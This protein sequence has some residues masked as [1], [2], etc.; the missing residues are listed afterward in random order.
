LDQLDTRT[1]RI[2]DRCERN[3]SRFVLPNRLVE[4]D[5]RRLDVF[6][7]GLQVLLVEADFLNALRTGS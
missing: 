3:A 1:P 2:G 4:L 6:D 7:E 5:A